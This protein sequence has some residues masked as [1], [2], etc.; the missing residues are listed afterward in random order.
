MT[1]WSRRSFASLTITSRPPAPSAASR[2]LEIGCG[3]GALMRRMVTHVGVKHVVGLTLSPSQASWV[4]QIAV[5]GMEVREEDWRDHK[6]DKPYDAAISVAAFEA[7]RPRRHQSKREAE[8]LSGLLQLL[9]PHAGR[10]RTAVDPDDRL[11]AAVGVHPD[12]RRDN[13]QTEKIFPESELPLIWE[14]IAAAQEHFDL[15]ALR[16]DSDALLSDA[17]AVGPITWPTRYDEAAAMVGRARRAGFPAVSA[18]L[19]R[20]LQARQVLPDANELRQ[21]ID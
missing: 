13:C 2:V 17:Q 5:P 21:T 4:R 14:P 6:P 8:G 18:L 16:N 11:Y 19:G 10:R 9:P 3:W 1:T 7:Y 20:R 12:V 15:L